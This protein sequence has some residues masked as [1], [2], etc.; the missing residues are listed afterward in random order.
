MPE[1]AV[2]EPPS[3]EPTPTYLAVHKGQRRGEVELVWRSHAGSQLGV[4]LTV[5]I[6]GR[7]NMEGGLRNDGPFKLDERGCVVVI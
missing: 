7:I 4:I 5:Q 2:W 1:F 3:Q 6:D